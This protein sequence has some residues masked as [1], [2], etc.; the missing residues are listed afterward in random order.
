[1]GKLKLDLEALAVTTFVTGTDGSWR[2][3]VR[4]HDDTAYVTCIV[5][6]AGLCLPDQGDRT[7]GPDCF[8]TLAREYCPGAGC[9]TVKP[10]TTVYS[11]IIGV[12][13]GGDCAW[14]AWCP[15]GAPGGGGYGAPYC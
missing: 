13:A 4:G 15:T 11:P 12:S 1:M 2:G 5:P 14:S 10:D 9:S 6:T 7:L 8:L 3:T